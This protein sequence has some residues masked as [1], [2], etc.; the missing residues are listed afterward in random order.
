MGLRLFYE[1]FIRLSQFFSQDS[2]PYPPPLPPRTPQSVTVSHAAR[3]STLSSHLAAC[4]QLL[5]EKTFMIV[6]ARSEDRWLFLK[7]QPVLLTTLPQSRAIEGCAC[8][9]AIALHAVARSGRRQFDVTRLMPRLTTPRR[10]VAVVLQ[11]CA[12]DFVRP[13][14]LHA[15]GAKRGTR[16]HGRL[17]CL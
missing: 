14:L 2:Q 5:T 7:Y 13:N 10:D 8:T 15:A 6:G 16:G 3:G 12:G 9:T 17:H 11:V 4:C 1:S